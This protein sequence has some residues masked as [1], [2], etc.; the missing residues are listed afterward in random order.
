MKKLRFTLMAFAFGL[1]ACGSSAETERKLAELEQVNAQK[2]SL[3]QEVAISSRLISDINGELAKARIRNNRLHVSSETPMTASTDT[4]MAKLRYVVARVSEVESALAAS[5]ERVK[6]L[7]TVSDSLRTAFDTTVSNLQAVIATQKNTIDYLTD[8]VTTLTEENVALRDSLATGYYVIGTRD[9][10]KKKGI[11]TEQGGG[12]VLF[13]LWRTGKTL[14]P[15][16]NLDPR[17]F[18]A[19][20]TRQVTQIPL[21]S[22][23]AE[24]RVASLQDLDYVAEERADGKFHDTPTLTITS[25]ADFWRNSKF[26]IIIREGSGNTMAGG[27]PQ[28]S[29]ESQ[30]TTR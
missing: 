12:R 13:V 22:A 30:V 18:S 3:M 4:L 24:Y 16:R 26:L 8:H 11:L 5:R 25:P 21:P 10:L 20:D 9:E 7:T 6:N 28:T 14:Q 23:T 1:A 2:D 19:I 15:A 27:T 17:D 29:T